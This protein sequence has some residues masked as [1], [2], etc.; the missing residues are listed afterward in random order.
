MHRDMLPLNWYAFGTP[1]RIL[2]ADAVPQPRHHGLSE[3]T[4]G[5]VHGCRPNSTQKSRS[6]SG[7]REELSLNPDGIN[8]GAQPVLQL[9]SIWNGNYFQYKRQ[10]IDTRST[11]YITSERCKVTIYLDLTKI[12]YPQSTCKL[13]CTFLP[14]FCLKF[15]L[16]KTFRT[17][18][19]CQ[20]TY[21]LAFPFFPQFSLV[22][23]DVKRTYPGWDASNFFR[24]R[25]G[26][27][28]RTEANFS[29]R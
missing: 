7:T 4:N 10:P 23:L 11:M 29:Y 24:L 1:N 6:N 16:Q 14:H 3:R 15:F 8:S 25:H 26:L 20:R 21:T 17:S 27:G 28:R 22:L 2:K 13:V 19:S 9:N 18:H 5:V 12:F